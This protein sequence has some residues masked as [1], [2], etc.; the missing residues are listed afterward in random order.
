M[1]NPVKK[2]K[3]KNRIVNYTPPPKKK[4][5]E[6][7]NITFSWYRKTSSR[8]QM[9]L[10]LDNHNLY[11]SEVLN[12]IYMYIHLSHGNHIK[13]IEFEFIDVLCHMQWY[14]SHIMWRHRCAGGLKKKLYLRSGSQRHRHFAG[15]F[16]VTVLHR[17]GPPFLYRD[18]DIP[19]HFVAFY[20]TLGIHR[21]FSRLKPPVSSRGLRESRG[22]ESIK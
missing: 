21:T 20:D 1:Q 13:R 7:K 3:T 16:N 9:I 11:C 17:H 19:S 5:T 10:P 2:T 8:G 12:Y 14:F 15:F 4:P 22:K 18:S 6:T